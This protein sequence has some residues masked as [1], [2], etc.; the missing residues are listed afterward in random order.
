MFGI[1]AHEGPKSA[2][3]FL[4]IHFCPMPSFSKPWF[5][6]F[7]NPPPHL[8]TIS[9]LVFPYSFFPIFYLYTLF[10]NVCFLFHSLLV[11]QPSKPRT[12]NHFHYMSTTKQL[13]QLPVTSYIFTVIFKKINYTCS[14]QVPRETHRSTRLLQQVAVQRDNVISITLHQVY[15]CR[16][17]NYIRYFSLR[18]L[19]NCPHVAGWTAFQ[20]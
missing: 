3:L 15:Y 14:L 20:T 16:L 18:Q 19:I 12:L 1:T 5:L 17:L 9:S 6:S 8:L 7:S 13:M 2:S 4:P 10:N 11:S